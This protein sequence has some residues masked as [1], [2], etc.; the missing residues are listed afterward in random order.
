VI[1]EREVRQGPLAQAAAA[2]H[3][4]A[5]QPAERPGSVNQV[6]RVTQEVLKAVA[7]PVFVAD[8][9]KGTFN[10]IIQANIQQL[11]SFGKLLENVTKTVD[12]FMGD[13]I[14]DEQA[15]DWLQHS[16]PGHIQVSGGKAVPV[17]GADE[18]AAPTSNA[19]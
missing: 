16:Y 6:A 12:E 9:I 14:T 8:L 5:G 15:R 10:A 4:R 11:E 7:F 17:D 13:N 19:S 3:R 18:K 2:P 1:R